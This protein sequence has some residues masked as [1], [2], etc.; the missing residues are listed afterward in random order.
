V[1]LFRIIGM[2]SAL[3]IASNVFAQSTCSYETYVWNTLEKR[4]MHFQKVVH[5]FDEMTDQERDPI[6]GCTVC[7]EDQV[8]ID[9]S[10]LNPFYICKLIAPEIK[11]TLAALIRSGER[12]VHVTGYRVGKTRGDI[13]ILG[14]R[15]KYSNHSY[16]TAIDINPKHNGLYDRCVE[17]GSGCRLVRGGQWQPEEEFESI[18]PNGLIVRAFKELGY[19]WG[20]EIRG[21]Q[22]DFM[23]FSLTG[24]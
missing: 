2:I 15:T 14:N 13:D 17:F 5:P 21:K 9:I 11:E 12:I 20:G 23:H 10:S 4:A 3:M 16:G 6:T 1:K 22:K 7:R 18:K 8:R 24:Y 19:L